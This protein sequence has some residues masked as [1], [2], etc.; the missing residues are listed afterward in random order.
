MNSLP[1][2]IRLL[3]IFLAGLA[4]LLGIYI[5]VARL[6]F[7]VPPSGSN[8]ASLHG[9]LMAIGFL[10]TLIGLEHAVA[11]NRWWVYGVPLLSLLSAF[12]LVLGLPAT[13]APFFAT[14]AALLLAWCFADLYQHQHEDH[15]IIMVLSATLLF[16]GNLLWL[17]ALPL[18]RIVPWWAGFSILL[19]GGER[20]ELT[21]ARDPKP[22]VQD[23][24]RAA[25]IILVG[26][27]ALSPFEFRLGL[28]IAGAA[29]T[30]LALWLLRNDLAWQSVKQAG[31]PRFTAL[32]RIA[33]YFWLAVGGIFWIWFA[34]FF[35][36]GPLYDAM[37]HTVFLGF[38]FSA[39]FAHGPTVLATIT[40]RALPFRDG[41]YL[42]A[43]LLQLS[44]VIRIAGDLALLPGGQKWG[45]LLNALA[46]ALFILNSLRAIVS[47]RLG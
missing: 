6:G 18:H 22:L 43:G 29:M 32:N 30:V 9:P 45:G 36:A 37:L 2:S 11:M 40:Q 24:F 39:I 15:F 12:A 47:A 3:F 31:W 17:T 20:L 38:V 21:R 5:G 41:S 13:I 19:I 1:R 4:L 10:L 14:N 25:A 8:L 35:G 33:G 28:R 34:R 23:L 7:P 26:G 46:I 42:H 44:L 16:S 27:V